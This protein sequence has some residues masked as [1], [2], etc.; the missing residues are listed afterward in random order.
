MGR[1]AKIIQQ[2]GRVEPGPGG[3]LLSGQRPARLSSLGW[4]PSRRTE[5]RA[6]QRGRPGAGRGLLP[7]AARLLPAPRN[8]AGGGHGERGSR[9]LPIQEKRLPPPYLLICRELN[10]AAIVREGRTR[11]TEPSASSPTPPA[12]KETSVPAELGTF[13]LPGLPPPLGAAAPALTQ[14][15][16]TGP[17]KGPRGE[18][19][20]RPKTGY[21]H[22]A[23][24]PSCQPP[25]GRRDGSAAADPGPPRCRSPC[26]GRPNRVRR[27]R[28]SPD[29]E[30]TY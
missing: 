7:G 22:G 1:F 12:N 9:D 6:S 20:R 11:S 28:V 14:R 25:P 16:E 10:R 5:R 24:A 4:K 17:H 21:R 26:V 27:P 13:R 30:E 18:G 29:P 3:T 19:P 8:R 15:G 2:R 23:R